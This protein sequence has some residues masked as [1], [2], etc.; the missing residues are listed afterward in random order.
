MLQ[1]SK[2]SADKLQAENKRAKRFTFVFFSSQ[3]FGE[4]LPDKL[5]MTFIY[6]CSIITVATDW[7]VQNESKAS[8]T[9]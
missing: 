9:L 4:I 7:G 3:F 2:L 6:Y 1:P 8:S 5:V